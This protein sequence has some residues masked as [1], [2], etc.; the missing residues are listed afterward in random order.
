[1][2]LSDAHR[3]PARNNYGHTELCNEHSEMTCKDQNHTFSLYMFF[4]WLASSSMGWSRFWSSSHILPRLVVSL[5][6]IDAI[7]I[8]F[9]LQV[10]NL[11]ASH[12]RA[13]QRPK[14]TS[15]SH[16]PKMELRNF[17]NRAPG[18]KP[19]KPESRTNLWPSHCNSTTNPHICSCPRPTVTLVYAN[20]KSLQNNQEQEHS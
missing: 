11:K 13:P 5:S 4:S 15:P 1:M 8:S 14:M 16:Q 20:S 6:D 9:N 7:S 17:R 3:G 19:L 2:L 18:I 10:S 12:P